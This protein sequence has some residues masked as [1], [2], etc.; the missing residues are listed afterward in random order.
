MVHETAIARPPADVL[1]FAA[2]AR[3]WARWHPTTVRAEVDG[4][5][6]DEVVQ[7]G[8]LRGTIAW[9]VT[10]RAADHVVVTGRVD[11]PFMR[12]TEVEV[13]YAVSPDGA[14]TRFRRELRY[15]STGWVARVADRLVFRRH[16]EHQSRVALDRLRAALE[17]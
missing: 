5:R 10:E 8:P 14:G 12:Q 7:A 1:A 3:T 11:F 6:I 4:D 15:T 13:R 9:R 16:N 17:G 2:D